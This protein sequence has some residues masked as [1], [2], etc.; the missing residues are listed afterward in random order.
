MT[1]FT[2]KKGTGFTQASHASTLLLIEVYFF[3]LYITYTVLKI[4]IRA[5]QA[6]V[7]DKRSLSNAPKNQMFDL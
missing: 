6:I 2:C 3:L 7:G 1:V 4:P 5:I